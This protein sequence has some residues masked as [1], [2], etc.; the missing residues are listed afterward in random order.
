A[1][2]HNGILDPLPQAAGERVLLLPLRQLLEWQSAQPAAADIY[3][4]ENPQVFEEVITGLTR[5][6]SGKT[7]PTLVCTSGWPSTAAI[8][9]LDLLL[10]PQASQQAPQQP[11]RQGDHKGRPY[12]ASPPEV[13]SAANQLY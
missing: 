10:A 13:Q 12:Y 6:N 4:F 7:L 1:I 3:V 11:P 2:Y 5:S 9:L 8:M